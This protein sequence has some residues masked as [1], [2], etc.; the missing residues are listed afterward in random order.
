LLL[1]TRLLKIVVQLVLGKARIS[2]ACFLLTAGVSMT[3]AFTSGKWFLLTVLAL[4]GLLTSC[5]S[6]PVSVPNTSA[7]AG[8]PTGIARQ[9][10]TP[11]SSPSS[12]AAYPT[13]TDT[14][15]LFIGDSHATG[16]FGRTLTRLLEA[17]IPN[18]RVT[19]VASCGSSPSWWLHGTATQ[20]GFWYQN[21]DGV[22]EKHLRKETPRID[23]L[24]DIVRPRTVIVA[25]GS[26]MISQ[27]ASERRTDTA[28]LMK[29][30]V[31]SGSQCIW[32]GPPDA[33]KFSQSATN[34]V[35]D[36]LT[37]LSRESPC[38]VINSLHY[39]SYPAGG[40]G[41]HYGG[42]TGTQIAISWAQGVIDDIL[43]GIPAGHASR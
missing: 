23:A 26:N 4:V 28:M 7:V 11:G 20:C 25:L 21:T 16:V 34:A 24:L 43:A 27:D 35:Y 13:H 14:A 9:P 22:S 38:R 39:T 31:A 40:D 10:A 15:I 1:G 36:L 3:F 37:E 18:A 8:G 6:F 2:H 12:A 30:V 32:I 19:T 17:R 42:T 33:R 5:T 29:R 41:L